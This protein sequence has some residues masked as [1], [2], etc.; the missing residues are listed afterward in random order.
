MKDY[1]IVIIATLLAMMPLLVALAYRIGYNRA[2]RRMAED[3]RWEHWL[4]RNESNRCVR[5]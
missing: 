4:I 1:L 2:L 3:R 5:F